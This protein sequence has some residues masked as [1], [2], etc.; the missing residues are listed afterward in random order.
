MTIDDKTID[1][2]AKLSSLHIDDSKKESLK[3]ELG[4]IINFVEN[5]NEIDVSHIEATFT[6]V[7]GGTPLREDVAIQDLDVS[8]HIVNHAPKS[9]DGFFIVPKI[10]E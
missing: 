2:L 8:S 4:D 10:I 6:T 1:K 9:E 5:L 7:E 3:S